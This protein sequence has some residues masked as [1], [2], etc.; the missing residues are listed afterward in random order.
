MPARRRQVVFAM[1]RG[2]W[3][4]R[5]CGRLSVARSAL[6]YESVLARRDAPVVEEMREL[7]R[8]YPRY[9]YRHIQVFLARQE[10]VMSADRG[11]AVVAP[12]GLQVPRRC[13]RRRIASG[14]PRPTP[15]TAANHM[16][17]YDFVYDRCANRQWLKCLILVDKW[18]QECLGIEVSGSI[19]SRHVIDVLARTICTHGASR[20]LR[21]DNG[22]EFVS[23]AII[24]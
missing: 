5:A 10:Y 24:K 15:P 3:Q 11:L 4:R 17:A 1:K 7:A 16:W 6:G 14:R 12:G 8:Q 21:S 22:P 23:R 9:G 13:A 2:L 18:T 20:F 19:R